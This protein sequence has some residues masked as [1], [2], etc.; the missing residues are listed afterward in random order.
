M[1]AT[2]AHADT[3]MG[4]FEKLETIRRTREEIVEFQKCAI[5][6]QSHFEALQYISYQYGTEHHLRDGQKTFRST[7]KNKDINTFDMLE[8]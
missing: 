6:F 2:S 4:P 5:S 3:A 1:L 7:C 8:M